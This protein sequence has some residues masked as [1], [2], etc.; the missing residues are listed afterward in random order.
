MDT[1]LKYCEQEGFETFDWDT[2]LKD[3]IKGNV[4]DDQKEDALD[5][6]DSWVTDPVGNQSFILDRFEDGE[7]MDD[8]LCACGLEFA[9]RIKNEQY[10]S[11]LMIFRLIERHSAR[12]VQKKLESF[13]TIQ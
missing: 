1:T 9:D 5:F 2:F 8:G 11:A 3:A 7:P 4:T 10:E 12:L 13:G 6:V